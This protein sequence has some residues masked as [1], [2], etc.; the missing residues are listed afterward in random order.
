[1]RFRLTAVAYLFALL[2]ASIATFGGLGGVLATAGVL[3]F[4]AVTT[5]ASKFPRLVG[6]LIILAILCV[7]VRLLMPTI[8]AARER[9][10]T[11]EC[12]NNLRW[13]ARAVWDYATTHKG[14]LPVAIERDSSGKPAHS[15]RTRILPRLE[16]KAISDAYRHDEPWNGPNNSALVATPLDI[17]VCPSDPPATRST[18]QTN[19]F[20]VIG[21]QTAWPDGQGLRLV[22]ITDGVDE[23]ILLIEAAGRGVAWAEPRDLTFNEAVELLTAT[24]KSPIPHTHLRDAGFFEIG[25]GENVESLQ[26]A[27]ASGAVRTLLL[28]LSR[29]LVVALLT[30]NAGD[31][32]DQNEL[33]R[34]TLP[35]PAPQLLIHV[36]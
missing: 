33:E 24:G 20:A 25:Y 36:L 29:D 35:W 31:H 7:L 12:R 19:Y 30:A 22:S 21:P 5:N 3:G 9:S 4:W 26:V 8:Q 1:M 11:G 10:H 27:F 34:A 28:P 32:V 14:A 23:T 16:M 17:F 2:A 6:F 15:W 13:I 18:P